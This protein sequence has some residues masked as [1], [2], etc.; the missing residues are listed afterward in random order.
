M[1]LP[2]NNLLA[3]PYSDEGRS[4]RPSVERL[5]EGVAPIAI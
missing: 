3:M 4:R 1:P 2:L 5:R